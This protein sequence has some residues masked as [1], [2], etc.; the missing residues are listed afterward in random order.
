VTVGD[1]AGVS[2]GPAAVRTGDAGVDGHH[3]VIMVISKQPGV[4]T[5]ALTERVDAELDRLGD[6]LPADVEVIGDVFRQSDFIHRAIDNVMA[7]VRD[8]GILVVIVLFVFLMSVRTTLIT[9]TAIPLSVGCA[10]LV[11]HAFGL[12]LNT[13]T[14]GG[15]AVAVGTLVGWGR[16]WRT[17][18]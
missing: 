11:F 7:A 10:A 14:R 9:L 16:C 15:L 17:R 6:T 2:Y 5:V 13:M 18:R 4:D 3:G 12:C 1:V 8:G